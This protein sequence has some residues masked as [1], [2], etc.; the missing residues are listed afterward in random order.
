MRLSI[1]DIRSQLRKH[2]LAA[3]VCLVIAALILPLVITGESACGIFVR[4]LLYMLFATGLNLTN[5]FGGQFNIG[6]AGFMCVG[7]Y[8]AAII[9]TRM[10]VNF[11]VSAVFAGLVASLFGLLLSLPTSRLSGM[12]LALVTM[13]FSE[14]IRVIALNWTSV[15]GGAYGVKNIPN[16]EFFGSK[17]VST[18]QYYYL[19]LAMLL[20]VLFAVYRIIHSRIGRAWISIRENPDAASS[21]GIDITR[22]KGLNFMVSAFVI[23]LGGAFMAYYYRYISSDMFTIAAGHEVLAMVVLGGMGT[24]SGPLVGALVI[25]LLTEAF[26][27]ADEYRMVCYAVLIIAMM[28]IRPQGL[29]GASEGMLSSGHK[30]KNK[31]RG[32][33]QHDPA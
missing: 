4:I 19:I 18:R 15:T 29:V 16:P 33:K 26:R 24:M 32:G 12:Y 3:I 2:S 7:A 1:R 20:I 30:V 10:N 23:G 25:N 21:L 22:Y 9:S 11:I 14:I 31:K 28:W 13:G 6:S 8:A 27:F 17:I 5:G